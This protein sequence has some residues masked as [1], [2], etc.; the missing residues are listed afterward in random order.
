MKNIWKLWLENV[1]NYIEEIY[2]NIREYNDDLQE[3]MN[4]KITKKLND[5]IESQSLI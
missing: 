3:N 5:N 1:Y 4:E 2:Q